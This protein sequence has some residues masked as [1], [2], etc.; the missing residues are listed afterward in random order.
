MGNDLQVVGRE[1]G[2]D[3]ATGREVSQP[4]V[5]LD[6]GAF[7]QH[8]LGVVGSPSSRARQE[9]PTRWGVRGVLVPA[10]CAVKLA[11]VAHGVATVGL[12]RAGLVWSA[13]FGGHDTAARRGSCTDFGWIMSP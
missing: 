1:R 8:D 4:E 11:L 13:L 7:H 9:V 12:I 5:D 2:L 10:P 3:V 6:L